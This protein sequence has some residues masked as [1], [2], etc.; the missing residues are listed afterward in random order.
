MVSYQKFKQ[1]LTEFKALHMMFKNFDINMAKKIHKKLINAHVIPK[2]HEFGHKINIDKIDK[3]HA[4]NYGG[5]SFRDDITAYNE[6][7]VRDKK[8]L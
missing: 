8:Y 7:I 5:H 1:S 2:D 3:Y 4:R 6:V